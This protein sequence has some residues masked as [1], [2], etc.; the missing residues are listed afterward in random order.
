RRRSGVRRLQSLL[1]RLPGGKLHHHG[2]NRNRSPAP[3]LGP[4]D[5][6]M[7]SLSPQRRRGAEISAEKTKTRSMK[8]AGFSSLFSALSSLR[9][10]LRLCVSAGNRISPSENPNEH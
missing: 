5:R 4:K 10:S 8:A 6:R 7:N 1:A 3:I 9:L 2:Q